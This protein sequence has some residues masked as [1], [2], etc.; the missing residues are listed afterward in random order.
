MKL[1]E[2]QT[3]LPS[4]ELRLT[5]SIEVGFSPMPP[6]GA[7]AGRSRGFGDVEEGRTRECERSVPEGR[8]EQKLSSAT[9]LLVMCP[10]VRLC[11]AIVVLA[12][13]REQGPRSTY[14]HLLFSV[15][16]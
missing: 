1:R 16:P 9:T 4:D 6:M 2:F 3:D 7:V 12:T 11:S 5:D 13:G 10:G 14:R 15:S 8:G